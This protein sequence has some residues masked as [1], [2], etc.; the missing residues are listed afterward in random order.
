MNNY[1]V[2]LATYG[3]T[4]FA[5]WLF[6]RKSK[7]GYIRW[8]WRKPRWI[9]ARLLAVFVLLHCV[10]ALAGI[11]AV[12]GYLFVGLLCGLAF[13]A[14]YTGVFALLVISVGFVFREWV[15]WFPSR[16]QLIL[17]N[18]KPTDGATH[19]HLIGVT[20][21]A[22]SD[23]KPAGKILIA[24]TEYPARSEG[25]FVNKGTPVVVKSAGDFELRVQ[26][27]DHG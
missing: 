1:I 11:S 22:V 17:P 2:T 7:V 21:T 13:V 9:L 8:Q 24:D 18:Q 27:V 10:F 12:W 19:E 26:S 23:L 3:I 14:D 4:G 5:L 20:G 6:T 16:H 15:F 25:E